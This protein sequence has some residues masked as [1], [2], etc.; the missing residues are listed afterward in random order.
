MPYCTECNTEYRS[1]VK[2]C[3]DCGTALAAEPAKTDDEAF[4]EVLTTNERE[5]VELAKQV[6]QDAGIE[7]FVRDMRDAA[8]PTSLGDGGERRVAVPAARQKDA[9][10]LLLE[11]HEDGALSASGTVLHVQ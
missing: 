11:A 10:Q 5:D 3:A 9:T 8:F 4:I 7:F 1:G 6:L 2:N